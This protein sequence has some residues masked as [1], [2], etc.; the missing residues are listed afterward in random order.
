MVRLA[1]LLLLL[2]A[3]ALAQQPDPR[4]SGPMINAL[5]A[6]LAFQQ[7]VMKAQA[8]D[9]EAQKATLWE[10]FLAQVEAEKKR[11]EAR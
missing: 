10:W 1:L 6:Q 3:P 2:A 4:L 8:D 7:A 5:Q 11:A 9:A